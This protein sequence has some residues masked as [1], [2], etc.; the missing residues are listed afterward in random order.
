[1]ADKQ[2]ALQVVKDRLDKVGLGDF[3]LELHSGKARKKDVLDAFEA[4]LNR[5]PTAPSMDALDA[6]LRELSATRAALTEYVE[7]LNA[8]FGSFG[9]TV[10]E[11]MW[12]DRRR[13]DCESDEA[14][15]LDSLSLS[16]CLEWSQFEVGRRQ[17]VLDRFEKAAQPILVEFGSLS[18][19]PWY[20]ITRSDLSSV[21][22]QR[23]VRETGDTATAMER[24]DQAVLSLA[25]LGVEIGS[26]IQEMQTTTTALTLLPVDMEIPSDWYRGVATIAV[27]G[28]AENWMRSCE[29]YRRALAELRRHEIVCDGTAGLEAAENL[30]ACWTALSSFAP[31]DLLVSGVAV[32]ADGLRAKAERLRNMMGT[33][34]KATGLLGL[35]DPG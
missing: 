17:A 32:W 11:V 5:R 1:M 2:A 13:R 20:G 8:P 15:L 26:D 16:R 22:F 12:A 14:R 29:E 4:R 27:R 19:H 9:A 18:N 3:C 30:E 33:V 23:I 24:V 21:E 31:Q 6:K 34:A 7:T 35:E 25:R 28:A 10:H